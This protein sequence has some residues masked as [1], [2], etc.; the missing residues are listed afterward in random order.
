MKNASHLTLQTPLPLYFWLYH[1]HTVIQNLKL[2]FHELQ[3][4]FLYK[5]ESNWQRDVSIHSKHESKI[6]TKVDFFM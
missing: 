5:I 2:L 3:C 1:I 6:E 4:T